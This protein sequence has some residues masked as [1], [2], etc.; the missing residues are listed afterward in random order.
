L[1]NEIEFCLQ[2]MKEPYERKKIIG[3]I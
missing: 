1:E 3:S 2:K